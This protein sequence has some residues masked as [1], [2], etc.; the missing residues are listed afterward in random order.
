[1][2]RNSLFHRQ[3]DALNTF[4]RRNLLNFQF[5]MINN[6]PKKKFLYSNIY[7]LTIPNETA[8]INKILIPIE[9]FNF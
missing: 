1:M 4:N 7:Q 5:N 6:K 3:K 2:H 8:Y 9:V